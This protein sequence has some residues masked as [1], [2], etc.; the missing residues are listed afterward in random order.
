VPKDQQLS[1]P[2]DLATLFFRN[3]FGAGAAPK[4]MASLLAFCIFG[5]LVVMTFTASRGMVA[6]LVKC[7]YLSSSTD[8]IE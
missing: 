6:S 4:A 8:S 1:S 5:N 2:L 7:Y 3:V